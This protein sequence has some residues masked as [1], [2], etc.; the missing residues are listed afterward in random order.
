MHNNPLILDE[1]PS[2]INTNKSMQDDAYVAMVNA[3]AR[4]GRM[5]GINIALTDQRSRFHGLSDRCG[6]CSY[7]EC[8][9]CN[10]CHNPSCGNYIKSC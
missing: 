8:S 3:L 4:S 10:C 5:H 6:S 7:F 9:Y 2:L 1:T